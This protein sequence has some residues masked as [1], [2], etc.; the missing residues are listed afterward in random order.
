[1]VRD[2]AKL[3]FPVFF[4]DRNREKTF[5]LVFLSQIPSQVIEGRE[6]VY[7]LVQTCIDC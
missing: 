6:N 5:L 4:S 7:S 2:R 1:M 3:P